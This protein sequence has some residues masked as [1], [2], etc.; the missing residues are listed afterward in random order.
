MPRIIKSDVL[1]DIKTVPSKSLTSGNSTIFKAKMCI[2]DKGKP[3]A[4]T[5]DQLKERLEF[6]VNRYIVENK[7]FFYDVDKESKSRPQEVNNRQKGRTMRELNLLVFQ[8]DRDNGLMKTLA[9]YLFLEYSKVGLTSNTSFYYD[10]KKYTVDEACKFLYISDELIE[11]VEPYKSKTRLID[12]NLEFIKN[13]FDNR[14]DSFYRMYRRVLLYH[15]VCEFFFDNDIDY[16]DV[17]K[18]YMI[19]SSFW[20][21]TNNKN[22]NE[23]ELVMNDY[24]IEL[25]SEN[26]KTFCIN[27]AHSKV[28]IPLKLTKVS[29][30]YPKIDIKLKMEPKIIMCR[31][32]R[33][34]CLSTHPLNIKSK[35]FYP[36]NCHVKEINE[37][38][39]MSQRAKKAK[40]KI[41]YFVYN[42]VC[43]KNDWFMYCN[44]DVLSTNFNLLKRNL[45]PI[46]FKP[47][48]DNILS[49]NP[50]KKRILSTNPFVNSVYRIFDDKQ[51]NLK[52]KR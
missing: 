6:R 23:L 11:G 47:S 7:P 42:K 40:L 39:A 25:M 32:V 50:L 37:K 4:A 30:V 44:D 41:Y 31:N 34:F 10:D 24:I 45:D 26:F 51:N 27:W 48:N 20:F 18:K 9:L 36:N 35:P 22:D 33:T 14:N 3:V 5:T 21:K 2:D 8:R 16:C 1:L 19:N 49:A 43:F 12:E 38:I 28:F 17:F 15:P 13:F 46:K 29:Y 52:I